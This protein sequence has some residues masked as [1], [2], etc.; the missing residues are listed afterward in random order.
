MWRKK[1]DLEKA[2]EELDTEAEDKAWA[3]KKAIYGDKFNA[4]KFY[5]LSKFWPNFWAIVSLFWPFYLILIIKY[6][7]NLFWW[8]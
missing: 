4:P 6:W 2:L 5:E 7:S 1:S 8:F 3:E